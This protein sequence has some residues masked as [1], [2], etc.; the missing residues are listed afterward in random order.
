MDLNTFTAGVIPGGLTE[1]GKIKILICYVLSH[2]D[3]SIHH[4]DLLEALTGRG[5]VN[6]FECANALGELVDGGYIYLDGKRRYS[7]LSLGRQIADELSQGWLPVLVRER[8]MEHALELQ[9]ISRN[10]NTHLA[11]YFEKEDGSV[12]LRCEVLDHNNRELFAL[13]MEAPSRIHAGQIYNNFIAKAED[14]YRYC[15]S[16]LIEEES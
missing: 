1:Y 11:H 10:R 4:D 2:L 15:T 14:I 12:L 8:V 6:Y 5:Q 7:L 9:K 13:E 16:M 3:Y